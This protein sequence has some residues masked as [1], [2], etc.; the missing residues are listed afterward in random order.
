MKAQVEQ[1]EKTMKEAEEKG[2][3]EKKSA[4]EQAEGKVKEL[5]VVI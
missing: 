3:Q 5:E 4:G 1:I 2:L